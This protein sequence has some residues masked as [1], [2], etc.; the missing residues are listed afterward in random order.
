MNTNQGLVGL[1]RATEHGMDAKEHISNDSSIACRMQIHQ[2]LFEFQRSQRAR[3]NPSFE[4]LEPAKSTAGYSAPVDMLEEGEQER[5]DAASQNSSPGGPVHCGA[6]GFSGAENCARVRRNEGVGGSK[7][8]GR[9]KSP[10]CPRNVARRTSPGSP[11]KRRARLLRLNCNVTIGGRADASV[12]NGLSVGT[13]ESG[14]G[15]D[16]A[17]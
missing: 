17:R 16:C 12:K 11:T 5:T 2:I 14:N 15:T 3:S 13:V 4:L 10:G 7:C 8:T 1:T 6:F 9:S